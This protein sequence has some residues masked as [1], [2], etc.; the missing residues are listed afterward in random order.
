MSKNVYKYDDMKRSEHM[1]V[2]NTVGWYL[3][4]HQL[5][6]VTGSDATAFLDYIFPNNIANLSVGRE[7]YTVMLDDN[8]EIIDDVVVF[9]VKE[10]TYWISTLFIFDLIKWLNAKKGDRNVSY[11]N[12][13]D[14]QV[15]FAVQGPKA[16]EMVNS[17]V[18]QPVDDLKFFAFRENKIDGKQVLI[19]RAGFTGEKYGYEIYIAADE[20]DFMMEKLDAAAKALGGQEVTDIQIMA[21][22]LPTEAGYF[23]M[24][25]LRHCNPIEAE[26]D[27]GINWAKD[28]VGKEVLL[29]IKEE[30]PTR[31]F[32]GFTMD[33]PD[34]RVIG[35]NTG[36]PG[37]PVTV[38]GEEIGRVSKITYSYVQ[39]KVAGYLLVKKGSVKIGDHVTLKGEHDAVITQKSFL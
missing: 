11:Q 6:E 18:E 2:R 34:T 13:T 19:N 12:I 7:R 22:T 26:L 30:G 28:F 27:K 9:R 14:S 25:D 29:K 1:A 17:L 32:V 36:G 3:W 37:H 8:A 39:E 16:L 20:Y 15:M 33:D 5:L 23:Y 10:N 24:R 21:W 38:D 31:E 4:T 35:K